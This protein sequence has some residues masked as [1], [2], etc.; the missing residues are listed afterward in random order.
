MVI[1]ETCILMIRLDKITAIYNFIHIN[2]QYR[3]D[4]NM[5]N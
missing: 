3:D 2:Q 5:N 1:S 4:L